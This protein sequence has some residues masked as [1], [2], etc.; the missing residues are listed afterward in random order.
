MEIIVVDNSNDVEFKKEI[1]R[2]YNNVKC[3]LSSSNIGMGAGNNL[4]IK[5]VS[6]DYAFILNPDVILN[7]ISFIE[8]I[9]LLKNE[10]FTIAAPTEDL[11]KVD[12]QKKKN[13]R[14]QRCKRFCDD[15]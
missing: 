11:N 3:I 7:E 1:E 14:S 8:I 12:F 6:N 5:N 15:N 13:F 10:K 2:K 4:G 9:N